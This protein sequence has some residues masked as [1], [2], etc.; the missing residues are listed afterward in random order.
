[1]NLIKST[2][3]YYYKVL[4][5][6]N[7]KRISKKEFQKC[8]VEPIRQPSEVI[9]KNLF[10]SY[11]KFLDSE[12]N[13]I[14][15]NDKIYVMANTTSKGIYINVYTTQPI[16]IPLLSYPGYITFNQG[17][18]IG[19]ISIHR[20][21]TFID[22]YGQKDILTAMHYKSNITNR[23][24][25]LTFNYLGKYVF[26]ENPTQL[27]RTI[28]VNDANPLTLKYI[29]LDG[30]IVNTIIELLNKNRNMFEKINIDNLLQS[31]ERLTLTI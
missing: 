22:R 24:F 19:H 12:L 17:D 26:Q 21:R 29:D 5:N 27:D 23:V 11:S 31:F 7:K 6:G 2:N 14:F 30:K 18:Q 3:G 8:G 10:S 4:K 15:I 9:N 16:N 13:R 20:G 25:I 28:K 1:M